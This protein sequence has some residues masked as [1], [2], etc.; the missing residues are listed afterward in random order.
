[1]INDVVL[2]GEGNFD[3]FEEERRVFSQ[4][5]DILQRFPDG[6]SVSQLIEDGQVQRMDLNTTLTIGSGRKAQIAKLHVRV[7]DLLTSPEIRLTLGQGNDAK[8]HIRVDAFPTRED[9]M[10]SDIMQNLGRPLAS[11]PTFRSNYGETTKGVGWAIELLSHVTK[12]TLST[13]DFGHPTL[14]QISW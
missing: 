7:D 12:A 8:Y 14:K 5:G 11:G 6:V 13:S 4:V 9:Q 3:P 1:M 2:T 10:I